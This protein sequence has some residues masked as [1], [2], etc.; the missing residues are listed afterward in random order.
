MASHGIRGTTLA[1]MRS[2]VENE[3]VG[4]RGKNVAGSELMAAKGRVTRATRTA[5]TDIGNKANVLQNAKNLNN[6]GKEYL[7]FRILLVKCAEL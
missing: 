3:A 1:A 4:P 7:N 2:N 5:M 6:K